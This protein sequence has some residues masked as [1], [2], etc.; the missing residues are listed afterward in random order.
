MTAGIR[1]C[2]GIIS[3]TLCLYYPQIV[4]SNVNGIKIAQ[5]WNPEKF[6]LV[7]RSGIS[8]VPGY[9]QLSSLALPKISR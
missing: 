8:A 6:Q 9:C 1:H 7:L 5:F 3:P 2:F 4:S